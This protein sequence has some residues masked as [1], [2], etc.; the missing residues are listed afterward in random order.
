MTFS[1]HA[2]TLRGKHSSVS[3]FLRAPELQPRA[4]LVPAIDRIQTLC[5][6]RVGWQTGLKGEDC[7]NAR[8]YY[9]HLIKT[10]SAGLSVGCTHMNAFP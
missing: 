2:A 4:V 10:Y 9:L 8:P 5:S 3:L 7:A 6:F 1:W